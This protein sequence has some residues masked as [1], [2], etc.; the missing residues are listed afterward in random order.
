MQSIT[1]IYTSNGSFLEESTLL[2]LGKSVTASSRDPQIISLSVSNVQIVSN[3][4]LEVVSS[5]NADLGSGFLKYYTCKDILE[6]PSEAKKK[7]WVKNEKIFVRNAT[8]KESEYIYIWIDPQQI[9]ITG[10]GFVRLKWKFDYVEASSSS[11]SSSSCHFGRYDNIFPYQEAALLVSQCEVK[12]FQLDLKPEEYTTIFLNG[13][14][15]VI[16]NNGG[17]LIVNNAIFLDSEYQKIVYSGEHQYSIYLIE[18][19]PFFIRIYQVGD[20]TI[21]DNLLLSNNGDLLLIDGFR[22][23]LIGDN[24]APG[25]AL[26]LSDGNDMYFVDGFRFLLIGRGT[27]YSSSS[28]S[29]EVDLGAYAVYTIVNGSYDPSDTFIVPRSWFNGANPPRYWPFVEGWQWDAN[30]EFAIY[31]EHTGQDCNHAQDCSNVVYEFDWDSIPEP[32]AADFWP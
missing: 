6:D 20:C 4:S 13:N 7:T 24:P 3:I 29:V 17:M 23:L 19:E 15:I 14:P 31:T 22:L 9:S 30:Y 21:N 12:Y 2:E 27:D 8:E 10:H 32:P 1:K 26:L 18:T 16:K 11:S 28:T 25:D 5:Q